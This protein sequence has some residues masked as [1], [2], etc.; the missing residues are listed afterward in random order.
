MKTIFDL[1]TLNEILTRL[2]QLSP[3]SQRQWGKMDSAQMLA[4]CNETLKVVT[5]QARPKR[6]LLGY[7]LGPLFKS[8]YLGDEPLRRNSPTHPTFIVADERNFNEEKRRYIEMLTQFSAGGEVQ[9][10]AHPHSFFGYFTPKEWGISVYKHLDHHLQ[11]FG[12]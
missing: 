4:H 7:I 3:S 5:N 1:S 12:V 2:E 10:T 11:Q 6:V 8:S 9:C